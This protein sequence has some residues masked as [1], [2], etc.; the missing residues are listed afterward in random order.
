VKCRAVLGGLALIGTLVLS[1][2]A[3]QAGDGG[4]PSA[5]T[6]FFA[7]YSINGRDSGQVVDVEVAD[8][9]PIAAL[10]RSNVRIGAGTLACA[11]VKLFVRQPTATDRVLAEPDPT[12]EGGFNAIKCYSVTGPGGTSLPGPSI[13]HTVIDAIFGNLGTLVE[14]LP[15]PAPQPPPGATP[16]TLGPEMGIQVSQLKYICG[17]AIFGGS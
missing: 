17:P 13:S 12:L 3:A 15:S 4:R 8:Q 7:C 10:D 16:G 5:L 6:S 2:T 9:D 14:P 11:I 1:A